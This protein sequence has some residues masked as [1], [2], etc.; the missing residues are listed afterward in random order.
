MT[1]ITLHPPETRAR[2]ILR[3][4][5]NLMFLCAGVVAVYLVFTHAPR[6]YYNWAIKPYVIETIEEYTQ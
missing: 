6:I 4:T 1:P 3:Y 2:R 5:T